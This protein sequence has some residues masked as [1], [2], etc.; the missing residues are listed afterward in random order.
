MQN[1]SQS[2]PYGYIAYID[3]AGDPGTKR[4]RPLDPKGGTEWMTIGCAVFRAEREDHLPGYVGAIL[5]K[6]NVRTRPDLHFRFLSPSRQIEACALAAKL[7]ATYFVVCSNKRNMRGHLNARASR[8]SRDQQWFYNW[9][10]RLLIERVSTFVY[11]HS[12]STYGT[13]RY[14]KFIFSKRG[15]HSYSQTAAYHYILREQARA[16][17]AVLKYSLPD[18]RVIHYNLQEVIQHNNSAGLQ[19]ADCVASSFYTACDSLDTGPCYLEPAKLLKPKMASENGSV[20]DFG[21]VLQPN[22]FAS[23]VTT[24]VMDGFIPIEQRGIFKFYGFNF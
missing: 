23:Q 15:G 13:P 10:I 8:I 20:A 3:E 12:V 4:V 9:L 1:S 5:Q 14:V 6:I 2:I 21:V 22:P 19:I 24:A 7:P 17:S 16:R 11:A 18:W